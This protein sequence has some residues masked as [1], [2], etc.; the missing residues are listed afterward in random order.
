M[1]R[2]YAFCERYNIQAKTDVKMIEDV[3]SDAIDSINSNI[4]RSLIF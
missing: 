2:I 1:D 3:S 4:Q